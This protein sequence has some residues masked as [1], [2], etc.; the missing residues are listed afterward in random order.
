MIDD[1]CRLP[2][3]PGCPKAVYEL[4][5]QC[6]WDIATSILI[7]FF[8]QVNNQC[9]KIRGRYN[10]PFPGTLKPPLVQHFPGCCKPSV[11]LRLYSWAGLRRTQGSTQ[12]QQCWELPW[13][14]TRTSTP[15]C[16]GPTGIDKVW[17]TSIVLSC[18][19]I[20]ESSKSFITCPSTIVI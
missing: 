13:K 10:Y 6:W 16:R 11:N 2:P 3:P 12:K 8:L 5:I 17:N 1:G 19:L 9:N 20:S 4:M 7:R 14:P 18:T 15:T